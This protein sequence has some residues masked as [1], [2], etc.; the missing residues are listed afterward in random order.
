MDLLAPKYGEDVSV[1]NAACQSNISK[2]IAIDI[3][4]GLTSRIERTKGSTSNES[5]WW[6]GTSTNSSAGVMG[7]PTVKHCVSERTVVWA[8][9]PARTIDQSIH[10]HVVPET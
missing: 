7:L 8:G 2:D 5:A 9:F 4:R 3:S 10:T 6:L 1:E